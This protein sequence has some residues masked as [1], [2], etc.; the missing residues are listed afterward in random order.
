MFRRGEIVY[1]SHEEEEWSLSQI[2]ID[3]LRIIRQA[4]HRVK[5]RRIVMELQD[6]YDRD[7]IKRHIKYLLCHQYIRQDGRDRVR[8]FNLEATFYTNP[9]RRAYIDKILSDYG[10][11]K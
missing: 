1:R 8:W 7:E 2:D 4:P 6:K 5:L 9:R 3:I 11:G 10:E